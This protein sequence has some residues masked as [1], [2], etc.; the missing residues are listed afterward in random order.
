M[1]LSRKFIAAAIFFSAQPIGYTASIFFA[2]GVKL[3]GGSLASPNATIAARAMAFLQAETI[4]GTSI[5][6]PLLLGIRGHYAWALQLTSPGRVENSNLQG[7]N[8]GVGPMAGLQIGKVQLFGFYDV[9]ARY[10]P[11]FPTSSGETVN[12]V[13][14]RAFGAALRLRGE[15]TYYG[16]EYFQ[17]TYRELEFESSNSP[18]DLAFGQNAQLRV[19][20]VGFSI[21]AFF[22]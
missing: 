14:P 22:N 2:P 12:F 18:E 6:S 3:M 19:W 5:L 17:S 16:L 7:N 15:R 8:S 21:G 20:G 9:F 10:V 4:L 1:R 13:R 11:S